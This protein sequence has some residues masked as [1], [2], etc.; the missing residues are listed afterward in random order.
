MLPALNLSGTPDLDHP[1]LYKQRE[2][3]WKRE[4][5]RSHKEWC[6]CGSFLNHFIL[7]DSVKPTTQQPRCAEESSDVE[8]TIQSGG[9]STGAGGSDDVDMDGDPDNG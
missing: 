1:Y 2:A 4:V 9:G 5:S 6:L 3:K 7:P 8:D